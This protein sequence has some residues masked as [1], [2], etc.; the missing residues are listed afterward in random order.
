[1]QLCVAVHKDFVNDYTEANG[2]QVRRSTATEFE[3]RL[4]RDG[5]H[6]SWKPSEYPLLSEI[7]A[8]KFK[9]VG[10]GPASERHEGVANQQVVREKPSLSADDRGTVLGLWAQA[11]AELGG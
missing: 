9:T 3:F 11:V 5:R 10:M 8:F 6:Y 1:M 7:A 4:A 2:E